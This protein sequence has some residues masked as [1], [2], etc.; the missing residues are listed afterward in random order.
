MKH[1]RICS[2]FQAEKTGQNRPKRLG[3]WA[4]HGRFPECLPDRIRDMLVPVPDT[5]CWLWTGAVNEKG[6]GVVW[7]QGKR[8]KLHRVVFELVHGRKPRRDRQLLH[9]CATR[10]CCAFGPGGHL[11][12]G[13]QKMNEADK[14]KHGTAA[15][16]RG[17]IAA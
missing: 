9:S 16:G 3:P 1:S 14:K 5:G 10:A 7:W 17:R 15:A 12:E 8:R 6:Y 11:R 13:T 4:N 2:G